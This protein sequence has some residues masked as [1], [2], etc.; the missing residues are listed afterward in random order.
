LWIG[1]RWYRTARYD[2]HRKSGVQDGDQ[3]VGAMDWND[4]MIRQEYKDLFEK[5]KRC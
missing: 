2:W 3:S 5:L 1:R 4:D